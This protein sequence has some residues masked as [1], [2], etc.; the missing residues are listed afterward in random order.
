[1]FIDSHAHLEGKRFDA[2]REEAIARARAAGVHLM[3]TVG[4]VGESWD[5]M[6]ASLALAEANDD[7]V[8][9]VGLHPHDARFF[10]D[11]T[12]ERMVEMARHPK[13]VA[14]GECGLD[15][16]YDNSPREAQRDAFRAQLR[17]ARNAGLPVIVHSRDAADETLGILSDE[18]GCGSADGVFHCFSYDADFGRAAVELGMYVSFSGIVTFPGASAVQSAAREL[19]L[20]RILVETDCPFLAPVPHRG[21]R[22]EPAFVV[23]VASKIAELRGL[24]PSDVAA[25]STANFHRLFRK[26][27]NVPAAEE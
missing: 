18:L 14:W 23:E 8:T 13:V 26:C 3:L 25:A 2:D 9:S 15:F 19:P 10:D 12:A 1:M 20:D 16:Y 22:N 21:R 17:L 27:A 4:Q 24:S 5:S 11:R 7:I 6:N